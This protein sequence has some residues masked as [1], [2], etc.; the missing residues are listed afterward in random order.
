M[1]DKELS[2]QHSDFTGRFD[3]ESI[4]IKVNPLVGGAETNEEGFL[5]YPSFSK[6]KNSKQYNVDYSNLHSPKWRTN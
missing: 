5:K 6:K 1:K 3:A 2:N 4:E